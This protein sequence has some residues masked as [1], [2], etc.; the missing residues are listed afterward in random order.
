MLKN[1]SEGKGGCCI[2]APPA[3][4]LGCGSA[5]YRSGEVSEW[6]KEHAW[7]VCILERVSRVRIPPSPQ[8]RIGVPAIGGAFFCS[9]WDEFTRTRCGKKMISE[10]SER[11]PIRSLASR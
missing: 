8:D 2:F 7:K 11:T 3:T 10:R 1:Y 4:G 6:L 9:R 5:R